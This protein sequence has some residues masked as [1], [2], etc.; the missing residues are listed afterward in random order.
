[1]KL[2]RHFRIVP[3]TKIIVGRNKTENHAIHSLA[4]DN[5]L[6]LYAVSV[7]GPTVLAIGEMEPGTDDLAAEMTISYSD[8][9]DGKEEEVS[10]KARGQDKTLFATSRNKGFQ[11]KGPGLQC[12]DLLLIERPAC[13][14]GLL[15]IQIWLSY[16]NPASEISFS[17][18][19]CFLSSL[20]GTDILTTT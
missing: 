8:A 20:F 15:K 5:D 16:Y 14:P 12:P 10:V 3:K 4:K 18:A 7:P 17:K 1:M 2:G 19:F 11:K 9:E 13:Y 6:L